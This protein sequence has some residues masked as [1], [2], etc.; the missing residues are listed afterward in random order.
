MAQFRRVTPSFS[1]AAQIA[2]EDLAR[3]AAEG[4]KTIIVNRPEGEDPGQPLAA[5]VRAAAEALGLAFHE[6]PF[7][8]APPPAAISQTSAILDAAPGPVLAYCRT[9][10][11][12]IMAWAM[13]AALEGLYT[14]DEIMAAARGAGYDL[15]GV[16]DAIQGLAPKP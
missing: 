14:P 13:A 3:A 2:P 12:S 7:M 8:G 5:D 6:V 11:R 9:G 10:R 16:R 1:V 15:E 4:F